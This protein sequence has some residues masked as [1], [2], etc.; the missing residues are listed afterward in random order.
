[1]NSN[2]MDYEQF[3]QEVRNYFQEKSES[4]EKVDI[5]IVRKNNGIILHGLTIF[6]KG[7]KVSPTIY[8]EEFYE[9]YMQGMP[10]ESVL[11]RMH[12][13]YVQRKQSVDIEIQYFY[14]YDSVRD[15]LR[16][17]LIHYEKN[18]KFLEKI[19][20]IRFLDFAV[21][22]Y[23]IIKSEAL[24]HFTVTI[25]EEH[26]DMWKITK[27][28]LFADALRTS[29][30]YVPEC[31]LQMNELL[32]KI[33][34]NLPENSQED[35]SDEPVEVGMCILTNSNK[36][37]GAAVMCYPKVLKRCADQYQS[38]FYMIPSSI[39]ETILLPE[40][41]ADPQELLTMVYEVNTRH[42]AKEEILS[43][44]I[45]RYYRERDLLEDIVTGDVVCMEELW[46]SAEL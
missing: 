1:M 36:F 16:I 6:K 17:K 9:F 15:T 22:C 32:E 41:E 4:Y 46:N 35:F 3:E 12:T 2:G 42:V 14:Q 18:Q 38:D 28:Q 11:E 33:Q 5:R 39:H 45:Y 20:H 29:C 27:E 7:E 31:M 19:P 25:G 10:M 23:S 44:H 21:I 43:Y 30:R 24:Q 34:K 37:D 40:C 8:L 13:V 26:L